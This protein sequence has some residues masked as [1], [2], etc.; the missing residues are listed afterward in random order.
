MRILVRRGN[1]LDFE[2]DAVLLFHHSDVVPLEGM[3][4]LLDWRCNAILSRLIQK[5]EGLL[6]FGRM[7]ILAP[8]GKIPS[9]KALVT[10]LGRTGS[11][12]EDLRAEALKIALKGAWKIGGTR[13][14]IDTG[15][16]ERDL[17]GDIGEDLSRVLGELALPEPFTVALFRS[18]KTPAGRASGDPEP[19][20]KTPEG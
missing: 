7:S 14:A 11:L 16:L 2:G 5:K 17:P 19:A 1:C 15:I 4:A 3:V 18:R 20:G 9:E 12:D 8:Q 6:E 10:G 13:V